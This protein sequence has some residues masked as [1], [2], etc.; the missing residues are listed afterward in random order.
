M[1]RK[2]DPTPVL[3]GLAEVGLM[4][5]HQRRPP[6]LARAVITRPVAVRAFAASL[7][8][9]VAA[10]AH[11]PW[12]SAPAFAQT[13]PADDNARVRDLLERWR[14]ALEAKSID[15]CAEL[16]VAMDE[17][18]RDALRKYFSNAKELRVQISEVDI[19]FAGDEAV[20]T[21]TRTDRFTE[22]LTGR[23]VKLDV[24]LAS[25]LTKHEGRWKISG[26]KKPS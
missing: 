6:F 8:S 19:T 3:P 10:P 1:V 13:A 25:L 7:V 23:D 14:K 9:V 15:G 4:R 24:T 22:A 11:F 12:L 20:A 18:Q 16:Q 26:L 5:S 21:F 2:R 17:R